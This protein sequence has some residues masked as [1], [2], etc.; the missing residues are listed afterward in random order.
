MMAHHSRASDGYVDN[1]F[2]QG[3]TKTTV[4]RK[5]VSPF[6]YTGVCSSQEL[7]LRNRVTLS[8]I[9]INGVGQPYVP[10]FSADQYNHG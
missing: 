8:N 10:A 2:V 1:V 7:I 3:Y 9:K 6:V 5:A 4:G